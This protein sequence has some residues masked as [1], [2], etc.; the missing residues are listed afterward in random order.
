MTPETASVAINETIAPA[1]DNRPVA[2]VVLLAGA[3]A[4]VWRRDATARAL[5]AGP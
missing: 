4:V 5:V 2:L 3:V 1:P